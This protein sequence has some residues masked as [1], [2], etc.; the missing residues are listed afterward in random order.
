[1]LVK[2]GCWVQGSWVQ[3]VAG[4]SKVVECRLLVQQGCWCIRVAGAA[5]LLGAAE[6]LVQHGC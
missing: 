3:Y 1:M 6:L 2:H 5:G 4:C